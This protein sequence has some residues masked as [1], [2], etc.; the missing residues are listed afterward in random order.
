MVKPS[1]MSETPNTNGSGARLG[2]RIATSALILSLIGLGAWGYWTRW[3]AAPP[4]SVS[5]MRPGAKAAIRWDSTVPATQ[6][7]PEQSAPQQ[8]YNDSSSGIRAPDYETNLACF[9]HPKSQIDQKLIAKLGPDYPGLSQILTIEYPRQDPKIVRQ[10]LD[11][12]LEAAKGAPAEKKPPL[13]LAADEIAERLALPSIVPPNPELR[14]QLNELA[15]QGLTFTW[16]ELD[17]GWFYGRDLLWRLWREYPSSEEGED[18]FVL[19][20]RQGWDKSPCCNTGGR[21]ADAFYKVIEHGEEF[22]S[23]RPQ[24]AH[25]QEVLFLVAQAYETWWSLSQVPEQSQDE[26]DPPPTAYRQ[27]AS[28]AHDKAISYYG[29]IVGAAPDGIEANCSRQPLALIKE[30]QD[31]HQRRFYCYC[32]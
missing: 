32:D 7:V 27:G 8:K 5:Q 23:K 11:N 15:A 26:G 3:H 4:P 13:L 6:N 19:L 31:T 22:L 20:L 2:A 12:L 29:E 18:A 10:F 21:H 14:L 24:G 9:E 1:S 17:G 28:A 25:H 30:N 16:A